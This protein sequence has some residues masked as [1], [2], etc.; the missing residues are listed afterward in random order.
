LTF[1]FLLRIIKVVFGT[2]GKG[3]AMSKS[4]HFKKE[5]LQQG[6]GESMVPKKTN[7]KELK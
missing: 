6:E 4:L 3:V 5:G 7:Q 2:H 1:F